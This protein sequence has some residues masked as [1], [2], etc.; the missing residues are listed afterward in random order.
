MAAMLGVTGDQSTV[1]D[2]ASLGNAAVSSA[3]Q[4]VVVWFGAE[5]RVPSEELSITRYLS[6]A[7]TLPAFLITN[8]DAD[9]VISPIQAQ[10]VSPDREGNREVERRFCEPM[11]CPELNTTTNSRPTLLARQR[12]G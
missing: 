1:F 6:I 12:P 9:P 8:G 4:A 11:C 7:K 2:D 10:R 3:V 5:D